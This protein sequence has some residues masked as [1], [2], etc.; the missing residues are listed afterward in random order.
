M[1]F[2]IEFNNHDVAI[3][4]TRIHLSKFESVASGLV[5]LFP[6]MKL[7]FIFAPNTIFMARLQEK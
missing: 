3:Q 2:E 4:L 7:I 1:S 6:S 5:N